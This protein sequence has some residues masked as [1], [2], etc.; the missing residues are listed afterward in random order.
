M[1]FHCFFFTILLL[2]STLGEKVFLEYY[3]SNE[4]TKDSVKPSAALVEENDVSTESVFDEEK[5][6]ENL[7]ELLRQGDPEYEIEKWAP[8]E[9]NL[10]YIE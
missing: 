1:G 10:L 7:R 5:L 3:Y 2:Q 8:F 4:Q 9:D 6:L